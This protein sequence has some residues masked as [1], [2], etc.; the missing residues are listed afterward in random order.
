MLSEDRCL[1]LPLLGV[2]DGQEPGA[3]EVPHGMTKSSMRNNRTPLPER[4]HCI[5]AGDLRGLTLYVVLSTV[6]TTDDATRNY[7][8]AVVAGFLTEA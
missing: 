7:H 3:Q 4:T 5:S 8:R 6:L 1:T 2:E